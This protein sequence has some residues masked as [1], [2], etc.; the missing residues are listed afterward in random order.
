MTGESG[1]RIWTFE[2]LSAAQDSVTMIL[3]DFV[4]LRQFIVIN[5]TI[6]DI[7]TWI[8]V[9][10]AHTMAIADVD[11]EMDPTTAQVQTQKPHLAHKQCWHVSSQSAKHKCSWIALYIA[12]GA[13]I[14]YSR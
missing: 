10:A 7:R 1:V 12:E 14:I 11:C 3:S 9:F 8:L 6:M 2:E 5:C 4:S 13:D